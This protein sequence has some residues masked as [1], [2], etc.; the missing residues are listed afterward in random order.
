MTVVSYLVMLRT[1]NNLYISKDYH[2]INRTPLVN[3]RLQSAIKYITSNNY[4]TAECNV[5]SKSQLK[6]VNHNYGRKRIQYK[7]S[8]K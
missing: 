3:E 2:H 5:S 1:L 8:I 7:F 6:K 4:M